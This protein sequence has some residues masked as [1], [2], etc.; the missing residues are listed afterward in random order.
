[1]A[2]ASE[3]PPKSP[4]SQ[5]Q[6]TRTDRV[7][8]LLLGYSKLLVLLLAVVF[9]LAS[10]NDIRALIPRISSFKALGVEVEVTKL[11]F[12]LRRQAESVKASAVTLQPGEIEAVLA[13][14]L[15]VQPVFERAKI[16]WVDDE[17]ANNLPF[18][19][20]LRMLGAG[21]EP[22]RSTKEALD[23]AAIDQFDLIVSDIR[24][25]KEDGID[26]LARLRAAGVTC[27]AVF[28][29]FQVD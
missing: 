9:A 3:D 21:V 25:E 12:A 24:R 1:M 14:A 23:L 29:V 18:R 20:L 19:Q 5:A 10:W 28:Y 4:A 7:L 2:I 22:A 11:E 16:L 6:T 15:K 26:G 27:P 13:R 17:P 8:I